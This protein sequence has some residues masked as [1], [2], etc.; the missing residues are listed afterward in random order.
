MWND[1]L[2]LYMYATSAWLWRGYT[3]TATTLIVTSHPLT[4][5]RCYVTSAQSS[6]FIASRASLA[7]AREV[8]RP[9]EKKKFVLK[10]GAAQAAP[11]APLPTALLCDYHNE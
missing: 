10:S 8:E 5:A 1:L 4:Y 6:K 7:P 3:Q 11:A 2:G 9:A